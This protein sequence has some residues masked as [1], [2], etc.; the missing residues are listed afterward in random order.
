MMKE[1]DEIELVQYEE[2]KKFIGRVSIMPNMKPLFGKT[3]TFAKFTDFEEDVVLIDE[4]GHFYY[5]DIR[6]FITK[7]YNGERL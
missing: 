7:Y 3:V 4:D 1:G 5:W 6:W 2:A